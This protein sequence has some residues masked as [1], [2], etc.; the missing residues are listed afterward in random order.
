MRVSDRNV[1]CD[2]KLHS[3]RERPSELLATEDYVKLNTL[4]GEGK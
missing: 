3:I 4:K 2:G 1:E